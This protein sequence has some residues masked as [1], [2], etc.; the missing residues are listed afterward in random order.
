M[1]KVRV[2]PPPP[3]SRKKVDERYWLTLQDDAKLSDLLAAI[4]VP[5]LLA[6]ALLVS[7]NGKL[8]KTDTG[9]KDGDSVSFFSIAHGG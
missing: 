1:I 2:M 4:R 6:R 8:S 9:L 3:W 5:K 7:V